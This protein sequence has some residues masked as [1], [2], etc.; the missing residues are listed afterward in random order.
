MTPSPW[1]IRILLALALLV[2][3]GGTAAAVVLEARAA[4]PF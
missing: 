1:S 3:V 4:Y 2:A